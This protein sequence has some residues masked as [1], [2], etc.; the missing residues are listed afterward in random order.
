MVDP[1]GLGR[2]T[3]NV[4]PGFGSNNLVFYI[5]GPNALEIMGSAAV[6]SD[7]IAFMNR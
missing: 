1:S 7:A 2:G 3:A 6:T 5:V 4:N